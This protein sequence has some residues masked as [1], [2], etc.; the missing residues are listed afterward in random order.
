MEGAGSGS[1]TGPLRQRRRVSSS[2]GRRSSQ[3]D[4]RTGG[5]NG[6]SG[7][8]APLLR[9]KSSSSSGKGVGS[10][11]SASRAGD[12]IV[13]ESGDDELEEDRAESG[14]LLDSSSRSGDETIYDS[15][16]TLEDAAHNVEESFSGPAHYV[17]AS[18][19]YGT[20]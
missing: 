16:D 4:N 17:S 10:R 13:E 19:S 2:S 8:S 18:V 11:S 7:S 5:G 3:S 12:V 1:S 9:R 15:R 6:I 20:L 14:D